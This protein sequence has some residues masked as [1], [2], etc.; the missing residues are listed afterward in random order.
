MHQTDCQKE[1]QW[2][3]GYMVDK[4][5]SCRPTDVHNYTVALIVNFEEIVYSN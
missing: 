3:L 1:W 4:L 2:N 5:N